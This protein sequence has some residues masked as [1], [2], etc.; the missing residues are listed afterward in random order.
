M[1]NS[2]LFFLANSSRSNDTFNI[3]FFHCRMS[4]LELSESHYGPHIEWREHTFL[5]NS[6]A[7]SLRK[8]TLTV[9]T[10]LTSDGSGD[11][12]PP[13]EGVEC[14]DG[15]SGPATIV[16]GEVWLMAKRNEEELKEALGGSSAYIYSV[17]HFENA[18]AAWGGFSDSSSASKFK[19][20]LDLY[21]SLWC[22]VESNPGHVWYD[23]FWDV[24]SHTDRHGLK[25]R[26]WK[27]ATGP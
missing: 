26:K 24:G 16:D 6:Q 20:R 12:V 3:I 22:C 15:K 23:F 1:K 19:K 9:H 13:P 21:S 4:D 18:A 27:P 11:V 10:C 8:D 5:E 17:I 2:I 25:V 14:A 7:K